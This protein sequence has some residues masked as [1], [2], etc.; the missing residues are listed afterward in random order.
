[1]FQGDIESLASKSPKDLTALIEQLSGSDQL[2]VYHCFSQR[3]VFV[4]SLIV[5]FVARL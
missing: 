3:H 2:K 5:I 4:H 1:V